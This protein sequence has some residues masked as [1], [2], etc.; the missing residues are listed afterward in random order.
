[1]AGEF[2]L[3]R[4]R[5]ERVDPLGDDWI[6]QDWRAAVQRLLLRMNDPPQA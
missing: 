1:M 6:E 5:F 3:A 2:E 4:W